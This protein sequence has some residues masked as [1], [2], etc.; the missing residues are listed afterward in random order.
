MSPL[1]MSSPS[2]PSPPHP[3]QEIKSFQE[4]LKKEEFRKLLVEY[5]KEIEDPENRRMSFVEKER[6]ERETRK[7][8]G[9]GRGRLKEE[10][11]LHIGREGKERE[12]ERER[13]SLLSSS[14]SSPAL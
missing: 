11:A 9:E 6:R 13:E 14:C 4:A 3:P 2:L 8:A 1:P 10:R 7:L 5:A 12:R